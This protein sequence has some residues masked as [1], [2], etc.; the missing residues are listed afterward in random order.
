M[1]KQIKLSISLFPDDML[2]AF[3]TLKIKPNL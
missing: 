1:N 3:P 2:Q